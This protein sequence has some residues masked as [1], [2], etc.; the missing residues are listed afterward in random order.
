MQGDHFSGKPGNV[1]EFDSCL[2]KVGEFHGAG[3]GHP[4]CVTLNLAVTVFLNLCESRLDGGVMVLPVRSSVHS[5]V[6]RFVNVIF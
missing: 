2:G 4:E 6:T 1:R 3:S 5:F